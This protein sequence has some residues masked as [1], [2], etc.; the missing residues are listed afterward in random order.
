M[1]NNHKIPVSRSIY[2]SLLA[3]GLVCA[4][5]P[6]YA[7]FQWI[8]PSAPAA[9]T[10]TIQIAP[11]LPSTPLASQVIEARTPLPPVKGLE[12]K[13]PAPSAEKPVLGFADNIPLS[14]ALRQV[15]PQEIGFSVAKDVS[16][17]SL[18]SWKGG[19]PWRDVLKSMLIPAGLVFEEQGSLVHV[20]HATEAQVKA[21][22][23]MPASPAHSFPVAPL[24]SGAAS[25]PV[26]VPDPGKPMALVPPAAGVAPVPVASVVTPSVAEENKAFN[27]W[28]GNK[29]DTLQR[30]LEDWCQRANVEMNWQAEYDYPL[31][32]SVS[33]AG[34]FEEAVRNLLSGFQEAKPQP[35]GFLY[36]SQTAGQ[37]VLV[38]QVRGNNYNE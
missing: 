29:G 25:T 9:P 21:A 32:A 20:I 18:V 15:L 8:A 4:A 16:L 28:A 10:E 36:N 24:A 14:V 13:K 33:F 38:V 19:A 7:G 35:V 37:T 1:H 31:Q 3:C 22:A 6:A 27:T 30:V 11:E 23:G 17:G 34:S 26:S 12:G 5:S 2:L